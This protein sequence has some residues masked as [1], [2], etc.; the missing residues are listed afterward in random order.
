MKKLLIVIAVIIGVLCLTKNEDVIIPE[1]SIR[2]RVIANSNSIEDQVIK[3][4]LTLKL[5]NYINNL[6][7]NSKNL[8]Q[9]KKILNDNYKDIKDYIEN[10]LDKNQLDYNYRI[11][12]GNNYFPK[13]TYKGIVYP[14]GNYESLVVSLGKS[15]G[16]NWWCVVYPPLCNI[17][18]STNEVEYT[19]IIKELINKLDK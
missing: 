7:K 1:S 8:Y 9:A 19:T 16:L 11:S 15:D 18:P 17:N 2:F 5:S 6:L 13:K 14:E 4:D 12:L 10:Y 3:N